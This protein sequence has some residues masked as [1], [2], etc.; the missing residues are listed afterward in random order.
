MKPSPM[1]K[2]QHTLTRRGLLRWSAA[3]STLG[4]GTA[5]NLLLAPRTAWAADYKAL[6]CVYLQGGNDG[7]NTIVPT[8]GRYTQYSTVRKGLALPLGSLAGLG[9]SGYGLHPALAPLIPIWN[10]G[11]LATL[12]NVGPLA[13]PLNKAAFLAASAGSSVLPQNLYSHSDQEVLWQAATANSLTRTGW[14]GRTADVLGTVQPVMSMS[15]NA[16]FGLSSS[17]SPLVLPGPGG[18]FGVT[19]LDAA[20]TP[21]QRRKAAL[22]ALIADAEQDTTLARAFAGQQRDAL[23]VSAVLAPIISQQPGGT[24]ASSIAIDGAFAALISGGKVQSNLGRQLYQAAKLIAANATVGGNRQIY[25]AQMGGFD[26]HSNQASPSDP[27]QG[28]HADLLAELGQALAAFHQAMANLGLGQQVTLFTETDFG[29]TFVP[30]NSLGTDHGWGS[31]QFVLGGAV[32]GGSYGSYPAL[33][34]GGADDVG[35]HSWDSQGRWI[36]TTSVDQYAACL[37]RWFGASDGQLAGILPNLANF[38]A[39][40]ALAFV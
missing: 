19:N 26:T 16:V 9:S 30:N 8:D 37:L 10:A 17:R 34:P 13:Q 3:A 23:A 5:A 11:R 22:Q 12:F 21:Y 33:Q 36:P 35:S 25:F 38:S 32:A 29:R 20:W 15:G 18:T 24:D 14:G 7:L 28:T 40:P 31:M 2:T 4:L 27:A 39:L 6:V 1:M